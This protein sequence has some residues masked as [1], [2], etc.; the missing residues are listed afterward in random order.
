MSGH[1]TFL[2][3]NINAPPS[4]LYKLRMV[5]HLI[6]LYLLIHFDSIK[7]IK[8]LSIKCLIIKYLSVEYQDVKYLGIKLF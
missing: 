8:F 5:S 1:N 3:S 2:E 6:H 4:S 7:D